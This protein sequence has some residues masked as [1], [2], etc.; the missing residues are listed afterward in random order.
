MIYH[1]HVWRARNKAPGN[2]RFSD[3][4][5][6]FYFVCCYLFPVPDSA[7]VSPFKWSTSSKPMVG[8]CFLDAELADAVIHMNHGVAQ[9]IRRHVEPVVRSAWLVDDTA[10]VRLDNTEVL[11][12]AASRHN[13]RLVALGS[14]MATPRWISLNSP[15]FNSTSSAA[16]RSIQSD[17]P[18]I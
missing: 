14:C 16:R 4:R 7:A 2:V 10:V 9:G 8:W 11:E 12:G 17:F 5:R 13:M 3:T 6:L 15:A 18:S 1:V